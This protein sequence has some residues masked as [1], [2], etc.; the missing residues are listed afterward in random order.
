MRY[1]YISKLTQVAEKACTSQGV[2]M[3]SLQILYFQFAL[4]RALIP[5]QLSKQQSG[6]FFIFPTYELKPVS[7]F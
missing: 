1:S 2:Q 3:K 5:P 6:N 7:I 4:V